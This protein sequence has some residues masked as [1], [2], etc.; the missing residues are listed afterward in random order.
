[1]SLPPSDAAR[2][3]LSCRRSSPLCYTCTSSFIAEQAKKE[4]QFVL[5]LAIYRA[6][7]FRLSEADVQA[8][9]ALASYLG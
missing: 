2:H 1:M 4:S 6:R 9:P 3:C 5:W 7:H 8:L